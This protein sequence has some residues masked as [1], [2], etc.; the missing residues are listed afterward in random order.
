MIQLT[1]SFQKSWT[2]SCELE[3]TIF[4]GHPSSNKIMSIRGKTGGAYRNVGSFQWTPGVKALTIIL[5]QARIQNAPICTPLLEGERG[6][7]AS[8]LDYA[9]D[10]QPEWMYS[11]FGAD[12]HG[13]AYLRSLI[14]R[15]NSGIR[16]GGIVALSLDDRL[17][18]SDS[19]EVYFKNVLLKNVQ[20]IER[21][22]QN[23]I[24]TAQG[25]E[26]SIL[27]LCN[28]NN[29]YELFKSKA[30]YKPGFVDLE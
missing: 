10:K 15:S 24:D 25:K 5:L 7:L 3:R 8:S 9:L 30:I 27:S 2:G 17:L 19:I 26:R 4:T 20:E 12:N 11:M 28:S 1:L 13:N 16:R 14:L 29:P 23:I 22:L 21:V 18:S 6:S